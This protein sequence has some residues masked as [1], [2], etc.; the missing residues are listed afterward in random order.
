M[1]NSLKKQMSDSILV[2]VLLAISGGSMDAYS[3]LLRD[4][5]F[6][7]AQTGNMLLFGV[8]LANRDYTQALKYF[9]PVCAFAVGILFADIIRGKSKDD[10]FHW[11]QVSTA[12]ELVILTVVCFIPLSLNAVANM[13]ISLACGIQVESFRKVKGN[14]IATT[15]C[16]GN[17][18]SATNNFYEYISTKDKKFLNRTL[19][20]FSV[21][22]LFV[23]GAVIESFIIKMIGE[24]AIMFSVVLLGIVCVLMS[25]NSKSV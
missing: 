5:V 10:W 15:M 9:V 6:A 1:K 23:T 17:L 8:N 7:N 4:E 14:A 13:L 19:L 20:Y 12:L 3:Y 18:R 11:R 16:I 21:I 24:M 2:Y 25:K 22:V